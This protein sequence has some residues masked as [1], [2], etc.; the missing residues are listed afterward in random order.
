MIF[1][2]GPLVRWWHWSVP[3][4]L[5]PQVG[6]GDDPGQDAQP[7]LHLRSLPAVCAADD[8]SGE[9][10]M[11]VDVLFLSAFPIPILL[12]C[13][14]GI[15]E[16]LPAVAYGIMSFRVQSEGWENQGVI[17]RKGFHR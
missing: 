3:G 17:P 5:P 4:C 11:R 16:L 10:E 8:I 1:V 7:R 6:A 14:G 13:R 2:S 15:A 9:L 12:T